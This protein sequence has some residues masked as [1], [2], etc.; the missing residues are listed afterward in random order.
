MLSDTRK[1]RN[2]NLLAVHDSIPRGQEDR[3]G[4]LES[5]LGMEHFFPSVLN[6]TVLKTFHRCSM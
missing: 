1:R 2:G 5:Q 3:E 6:D 4:V